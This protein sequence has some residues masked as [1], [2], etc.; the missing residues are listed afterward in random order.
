MLI[1]RLLVVH[2]KWNPSHLPDY[3]FFLRTPH[4]PAC[5]VQLHVLTGKVLLSLADLWKSYQLL[6]AWTTI[7]LPQERQSCQLSGHGQKYFLFPLISFPL[8]EACTEAGVF[9]RIFKV[10]FDVVQYLAQRRLHTGVQFLKYNKQSTTIPC[11]LTVFSTVCLPRGN[12]QY[13]HCFILT[14]NSVW[15]HPLSLLT[16]GPGALMICWTQLTLN[17]LKLESKK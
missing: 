17:R 2:H 12:V 6:C 3:F 5:T 10:V 16:R 8:F 11:N 4:T 13:L 9:S 7:E 15:L 1:F 14:Q